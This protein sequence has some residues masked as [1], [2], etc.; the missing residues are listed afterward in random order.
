ML[1]SDQIQTLIAIRNRPGSIFN[2]KGKEYQLPIDVIKRIANVGFDPD[3]NS[4]TAKLLHLVAFGDLENVK[5]ML[6]INSGLIGK[7]GHVVTPSGMTVRYVKPYECALGAGDFEMAQLIAGYFDEF[8]DGAEEKA[9]QDKK[10]LPH[11]EALAQQVESK[12]STYDVAPLIQQVIDAPDKEVA[13]ALNNSQDL[14]IP[15][16]KVLQEFRDAVRPPVKKTVGLHYQHYTA[17]LQ[18]LELL[19]IKWELLSKSYTNYDRC[20]LVWRQLF[21]F[22]SRSLSYPERC[23]LARSCEDNERTLVCKYNSQRS[24]PESCDS[25]VGSGSGLG[26]D[27]A[28]LGMW[29]GSNPSLSVFAYWLRVALE[30]LYLTKTG[31]LLHLCSQYPRGSETNCEKRRR[32]GV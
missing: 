22:L 30:N 32:L 2:P 7:A 25:F 31:N 6:D 17:I 26:F 15:L 24:F 18:V 3:P 5:A 10:Y 27:F 13:A 1:T 23:A 14:S 29:V 28:I 20:N 11:I 16:C 21:G 19:G 8:V 9:A 12:K 4:D